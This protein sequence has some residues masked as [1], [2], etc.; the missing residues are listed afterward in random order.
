LG[1]DCQALVVPQL[2][3]VAVRLHN[4]P[5]SGHNAVPVEKVTVSDSVADPPDP[6]VF[7]PPVRGMDQDRAPDPNPSIMKQKL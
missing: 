3:D 6:H 5:G 1:P 2:T 4:G 7:E